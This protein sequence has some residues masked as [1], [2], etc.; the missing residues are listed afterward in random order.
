MAQLQWEIDGSWHGLTPAKGNPCLWAVVRLPTEK[1]PTPEKDKKGRNCPSM[2]S[3]E[4]QTEGQ[5]KPVELLG[6]LVTYVDDLL[7][8]MPEVHMQPV[9]R[10]LLKKYRKCANSVHCKSRGSEKSAFLAIFWGF[11]YFLRIACSLGIPQE[12]L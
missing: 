4:I 7:F 10:L 9:I 8:A 12:N 2:R 11:F 1:G 6:G 5:D 3:I